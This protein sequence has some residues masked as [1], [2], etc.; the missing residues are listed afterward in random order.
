MAC[1]TAVKRLDCAPSAVTP[2]GSGAKLMF[3]LDYPRLRQDANSLQTT[4]V[5]LLLGANDKIDFSK[6]RRNAQPTA[7]WELWS[8]CGKPTFAG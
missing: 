2:E 4:A 6:G 8:I 3:Y 7:L 1:S 5:G